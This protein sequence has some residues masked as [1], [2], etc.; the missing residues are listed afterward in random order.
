[1]QVE[2]IEIAEQSSAYAQ[3]LGVAELLGQARFIP[4]REAYA[5]QSILLGGFRQGACVG[6]LRFL[7]QVIGRDRQRTPILDS[8]GRLL[9]EGYVEAFGVLPPDRRLGIGRALQEHAIAR[10]RAL[11]CYQIRS[12]SP[13]TSVENYALKLK[14]GYGIHPSGENDSNYFIKTLDP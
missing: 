2:I 10:C 7:V 13:V 1:M 14:M 5:D 3:I 6:F 8:A 9:R 11:G 12:R 4:V